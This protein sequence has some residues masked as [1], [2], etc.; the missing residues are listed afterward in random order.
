MFIPR[1]VGGF[2]KDLRILPR[3][4]LVHGWR[5]EIP[6]VQEAA[7]TAAVFNVGAGAE[8]RGAET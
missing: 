3:E 5:R 4:I 6:H 8:D 2:L 1:G 7:K